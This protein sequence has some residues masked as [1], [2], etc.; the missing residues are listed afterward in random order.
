MLQ[1]G[2]PER[3]QTST[4]RNHFYGYRSLQVAFSLTHGQET[5]LSRTEWIDPPWKREVPVSQHPLHTLLDI[6]Y[7][8]VPEIAKARLNR[9]GEMSDL[10]ERLRRLDD[11]SSRLDGWESAVN[12]THR[13]MLFR[14][15]DAEWKGLHEHALEF[16]NLACGIAYAMYTGVRIKIACMMSRV[17]S[18]I[19]GTGG[20]ATVDTTGPVFEGLRWSR[21]AL[22]CLEYFHTGAP[23]AIGYISTLF[24][25]DAA[26]EYLSC[27]EV[28]VQTDVSQERDFCLATAQRLSEMKIPVFCWR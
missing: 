20:L 8:A 21:V 26:W 25:L 17:M 7:E 19:L 12:L 15:K 4:A 24:P 23:K 14:Q 11:I 10:K 16:A 28:N 27:I 1:Y 18:D 9:R 13:G 22:Q 2:G 6:A 5:F 3:L